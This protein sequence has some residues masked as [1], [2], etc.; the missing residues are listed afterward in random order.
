MSCAENYSER[1]IM[2]FSLRRTIKTLLKKVNAT[3]ITC[4]HGIRTLITIAVYIV[5][6]LI[7]ISQIPFSNRIFLTEVI[8]YKIRL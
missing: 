4:I 2:S 7:I 3:D 8:T 1:I 6:R 5:H